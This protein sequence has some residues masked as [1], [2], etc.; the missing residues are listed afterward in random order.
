[1]QVSGASASVLA[2]GIASHLTYCT[3]VHPGEQ[4]AETF[5]ALRR[6]LPAV[7]ARVSP[8]ERFGV[9]LRLSAM[10]AHQLAEPQALEA[11]QAFLSEHGLYVFTV[12]GFPYGA[13]HHAR[14]KDQVYL[15]DWRDPRRSHYTDTL[16]SLLAQLLPPGCEGS[17]STVPAAYRR[18]IASDADAG[19]DSLVL[20]LL[21]QAASLY[22]V[23]VGTGRHI[24][25][26]L[27][28]EPSCL[29]ETSADV[30]TFFERHLLTRASLATLAGWVGCDLRFAER[31]LR[32][33]LGV[34]LDACHAAVEFESPLESLACVEDAGIRIAKVQLSAGLHAHRVDELPPEAFDELADE[35]YL[36]QVVEQRAGEVQL[37]RYEDLPQALSTCSKGGRGQAARDWRIHFHVPVWCRELGVFGTTQPFL[38]SWLARHRVRPIAQHLEVE[39]YTWH[40]LPPAWRTMALD[41]A[42]AHELNWVRE[43]L[44]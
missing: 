11:F 14:V 6:H 37:V 16:V 33:H 39:T 44:S 21:R 36:H 27:E 18:H 4:W 40:V 24:V 42:I 38:Q 20:Q 28:P 3:N 30:V 8:S 9:G 17:I 19:M 10:A 7:K 15:P 35:V 1:M 31:V 25:L 34:C 5:E 22:R 23:A 2:D 29:L 43:Q 12:N 13:F 26:A 41:E 32:A